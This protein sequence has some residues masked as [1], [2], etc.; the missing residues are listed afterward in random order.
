MDYTYAQLRVISQRV[1]QEL[2]R[3]Q[4]ALDAA[5]AQFATVES[6]LTQMGT[7]YSE[8]ATQVNALATA[9]PSD[10]A[11]LALK[12]DKDRMV[13]EFNAS[14]TRATSLKTAVDGI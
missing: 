14:K 11:L 9:N 6:S 10:D 3:N 1:L 13:A 4:D 5:V 12:A 7:A 8:W 2:A